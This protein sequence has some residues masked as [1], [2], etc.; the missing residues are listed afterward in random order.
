MLTTW[1]KKQKKAYG[2]GGGVGGGG[3]SQGAEE[4]VP[5]RSLFAGGVWDRTQ[6]LVR[7]DEASA[8]QWTDKQTESIT[9]PHSVVKYYHR[10]SPGYSPVGLDWGTYPHPLS[11]TRLSSRTRNV[12]I[13]SFVCLLKICHDG[14][15]M[16]IFYNV[17]IF[18]STFKKFQKFL[19][20][21]AINAKKIFRHNTW[22]IWWSVNYKEKIIR[23]TSCLLV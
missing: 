21:I 18:V 13:Y 9:S 17:L 20:L 11:P 6:D 5:P 2:V 14:F 3:V 23:K 4:V 15:Q 8:L 19:E 12:N 16:G 10:G 7:H 22:C 1:K